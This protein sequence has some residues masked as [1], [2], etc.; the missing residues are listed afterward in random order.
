ME[1]VT[2]GS[3][4]V[5][6]LNPG[7]PSFHV[8]C[9]ISKYPQVNVIPATQATQEQITRLESLKQRCNQ[10]ASHADTTLS[11]Q[12][13]VQQEQTTINVQDTDH[14]Q[15]HQNTAQE[16]H[17]ALF[18]YPDPDAPTDQPVILRSLNWWTTWKWDDICSH[19]STGRTIPPQCKAQYA[20]IIKAISELI[21]QRDQH[22]ETAWKMLLATPALI[23]HIN[24]SHTSTIHKRMS[25]VRQG[26]WDVLAADRQAPT[27]KIQRRQQMTDKQRN[28]RDIQS[29]QQFLGEN[30]VQRALRVLDGPL[31][32]ASDKQIQ[33]ELPPTFAKQCRPIPQP[34][35]QLPPAPETKEAV[36]QA[37][38]Q[39]IKRAQKKRSRTG[40]R[41]I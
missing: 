36:Y 28:I 8:H 13:A 38:Y 10:T 35:Q 7:C 39:G 41:Q 21:N 19:T 31:Q 15:Q 25:L 11:A 1:A 23:L 3:M 5:H 37:I 24:T 20:Q 6:K 22:E 34:S 14:S 17:R 26:R 32:L 40:R 9:F 2:H 16:I 30:E 29:I 18:T 27:N 12:P 33:E 4:R